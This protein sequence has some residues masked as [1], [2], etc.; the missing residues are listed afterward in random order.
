LTSLDI[1]DASPEVSALVRQVSA[2]GESILFTQQGQPVAKL[3]LAGTH[4]DPVHLAQV[5]G[6]LEDGDPFLAAIEEIVEARFR[7]L[8]R[9]FGA[10]E[11]SGS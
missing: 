8:P 3:V 6:F 11:P 1:A 4:E 2:L 10:L 5:Q 7:H 9:A